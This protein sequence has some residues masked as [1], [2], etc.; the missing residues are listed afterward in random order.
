M[1]GNGYNK[2]GIREA[3]NSLINYAIDS[4]KDFLA[5]KVRDEEYDY[6]IFQDRILQTYQVESNR[7]LELLFFD[8]QIALT[9]DYNN[10][11]KSKEFISTIFLVGISIILVIVGC[12]YLSKFTNYFLKMDNSIEQVKVLVFHTIIY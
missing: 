11:K 12:V 8:Y 10:K 9:L 7:M 1:I 6:K 4:H 3:V 5:M 2:K